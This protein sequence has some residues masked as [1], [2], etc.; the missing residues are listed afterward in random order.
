M[1]DNSEVR[2]SEEDKAS[3]IEVFQPRCSLFVTFGRHEIF[4]K[5]IE[6]ERHWSNTH[7]ESKWA[8]KINYLFIYYLFIYLADDFKENSSFNW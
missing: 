6:V 5:L 2:T 4:I 7:F 3:Q 1:S 8:F